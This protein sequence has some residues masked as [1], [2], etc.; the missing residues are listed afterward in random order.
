MRKSCPTQQGA[1]G[2]GPWPGDRH[3]HS[4]GIHL[5]KKVKIKNLL[6]GIHSPRNAYNSL[7]TLGLLKERLA[8]CLGH[9]SCSPDRLAVVWLC[10]FTRCCHLSF[11]A[12]IREMRTVTVASPR[13]GG[14]SVRWCRQ[15]SWHSTPMGCSLTQAVLL[16][17]PLSYTRQYMFSHG[18]GLLHF[19]SHLLI[20]AGP[21]LAHIFSC[22]HPVSQVFLHLH[23]LASQ[24]LG[25]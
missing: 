14:S 23:L 2:L 6:E 13:A 25:H 9:K 4:Y 21:R 20:I 3:E 1:R 10:H 22:S 24:T 18:F 8:M 7:Q 12:P 11:S 15:G 19:L 17:T 5:G 16:S